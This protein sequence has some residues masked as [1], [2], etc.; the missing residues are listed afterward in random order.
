MS[1]NASHGSGSIGTTGTAGEAS[2]G[3]ANELF[4]QV[5]AACM[6]AA[7][8]ADGVVTCVN[9]GREGHPACGLRYWYSLR[10]AWLRV[11]EE[12]V[13]VEPSSFEDDGPLQLKVE[14]SF[15][16]RNLSEDE[17]EDLEDCLDA[18]QRPF[19]RLRRS[20][21]LAQAIACAESLWDGDD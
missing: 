9:C 21:P 1:G 20:V 12:D 19:P 10:A 2:Q 14:G 3:S 11:K 15:Q 4:A 8:N 13:A 17:V 6:A 7:T 18:V 5:D 16:V